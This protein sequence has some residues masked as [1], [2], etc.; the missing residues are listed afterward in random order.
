[1]ARDDDRIP[2]LRDFVDGLSVRQAR[3]ILELLLAAFAC[4][5]KDVVDDA[6]YKG[7]TALKQLAAALREADADW[8]VREH[9]L[10]AG[11]VLYYSETPR[12][13]Y[14]G[15]QLVELVTR[16][17][18]DGGLDGAEHAFAAAV[19]TLKHEAN[20]HFAGPSL[21]EANRAVVNAATDIINAVLDARGITYFSPSEKSV[22]NGVVNVPTARRLA[23]RLDEFPESQKETS[24]ITK[25]AAYTKCEHCGTEFKSPI[26]VD[27]QAYKEGRAK[28]SGN[29]APC[30]KCKTMTGIDALTFR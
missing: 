16:A 5:Q 24:M 25:K 11:R 30:P 27:E 28:L 15:E 3:D 21:L 26:Q 9:V 22:L 8:Y 1:M 17:A 6:K 7:R 14:Y 29:K 23:T 20:T 10:N 19:A 18:K 13:D 4:R 12:H 2:A